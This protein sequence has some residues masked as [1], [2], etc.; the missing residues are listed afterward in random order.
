MD[1]AY[2]TETLKASKTTV[3][4]ARE[5]VENR[6]LLT[7]PSS[8][9]ITGVLMGMKNIEIP[10]YGGLGCS[11]GELPRNEHTLR[12]L[13][14]DTANLSEALNHADAANEKLKIAIDELDSVQ[15]KDLEMR[16][17]CENQVRESNGWGHTQA[18]TWST[19]ECIRHLEDLAAKAAEEGIGLEEVLETQLGTMDVEA[20]ISGQNLVDT[21]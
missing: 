3:R 7:K 17:A 12:R 1:I 10:I 11:Y 13:R 2:I 15:E 21:Q 19:D 20:E 8:F 4:V 5:N 9:Y 6:A 18:K 16:K 14:D